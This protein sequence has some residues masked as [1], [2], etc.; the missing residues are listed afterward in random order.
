MIAFTGFLLALVAVMVLRPLVRRRTAAGV[1]TAVIVFGVAGA[2]IAE[3]TDTATIQAGSADSANTA[4]TSGA[5]A[6]PAKPAARQSAAG[7]VTVTWSKTA[8]GQLGG[9]ASRYEIDRYRGASGGSA[10]RVE[11]CDVSGGII[12]CEDTDAP[13]GIYRYVLRARFADHWTAE[14]IESDPVTVEAAPSAPTA[15]QCKPGGWFGND[16]YVHWDAPSGTVTGY[17][18]TWTRLH[19]QTDTVD[20][21]ANT[22]RWRPERLA[23]GTYSVQVTALRDDLSSELSAT[24]GVIYHGSSWW[25]GT[26]WSC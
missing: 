21:G 17:R 23:Y 14:S 22:T 20:V 7:T 6:Q 3:F 16:S 9:Q 15:V 26:Y 2:G 19:G 5:V 10:T 12:T 1:L 25:W 8:V 13:A 4:F 11:S 18:V 24:D